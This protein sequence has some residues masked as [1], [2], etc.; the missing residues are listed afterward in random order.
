MILDTSTTSKL[1]SADTLRSEL[2]LSLKNHGPQRAESLAERHGVSVEAV[3][4]HLVQMRQEGL[5][6]R[7]EQRAGQRGRPAL[8]YGLTDQG[9]HQFPKQYAGLA[10][11]LIDGVIATH[12]PAGVRQLLAQ[13]T[14]QRVAMW[15]PKLEG[16]S[17]SEKLEVLRGIYQDDDPF[18]E[19]IELDGKPAIVERNCPFYNVAQQQPALC[20]LTVNVLMRLLGYRVQRVNSFQAGDG[21]CVFKVKTDEPV[22]SNRFVF[23]SEIGM[24]QSK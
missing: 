20:S 2:L 22:Q 23:E 6:W 21:R 11:T 5:L 12:G 10:L 3:R 13:L 9:E 14:E 4:G 18:V 16:K 7:A 1:N 17:L 8:V 24:S 19:L 15:A